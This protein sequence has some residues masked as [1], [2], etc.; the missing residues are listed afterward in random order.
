MPGSARCSDIPA[1][2]QISILHY[3]R[4]SPV[5]EFR[6]HRTVCYVLSMLKPHLLASL[7][8]PDYII[9]DLIGIWRIVSEDSP[10][11]A[12]SFLLIDSTERVFTRQIGEYRQI[13]ECFQHM[14][15]FFIVTT[16]VF[17]SYCCRSP[18][19]KKLASQLAKS[20]QPFLT[21]RHWAGV[22]PYTLRYRFAESC[23]LVKQLHSIIYCDSTLLWGRASPKSYAQL[24]LPSS[25]NYS[26]SLALVL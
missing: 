25:L 5:E 1:Y 21:Y 14:A 22:S 16:T 13:L 10:P 8:G 12:G 6:Y 24:L 3:C 15:R 23:V 9:P 7:Q 20:H 11:M 26:H 17:Y 18:E 4:M 2:S 19:L